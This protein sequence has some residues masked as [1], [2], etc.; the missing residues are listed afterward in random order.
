MR[1]EVD[2]LVEAWA[3]ERSDLDLAPVEVFSRIRRLSRHRELAR[4]HAFTIAQIEKWEFDV[5][6]A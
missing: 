3:R 6:V 5:L 1:D 4:R 2:E